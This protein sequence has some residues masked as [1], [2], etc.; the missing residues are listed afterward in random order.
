[1]R[2]SRSLPAS[3]VVCKQSG[4]TPAIQSEEHDSELET[5]VEDALPL[6]LSFDQRRPETFASE[7]SPR[8]L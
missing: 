4:G 6:T 1:M 5:G 3:R 2:G 8:V 7:S